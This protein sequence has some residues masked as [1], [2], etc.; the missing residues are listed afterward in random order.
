MARPKY[1]S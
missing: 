1:C